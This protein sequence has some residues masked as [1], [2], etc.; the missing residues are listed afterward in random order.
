LVSVESD[1]DED[2]HIQQNMSQ[3]S[4]KTAEAKIALK[5]KSAVE[6][7]TEDDTKTA[8]A[9]LL[10]EI[11]NSPLIPGPFLEQRKRQEKSVR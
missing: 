2:E 10:Y 4:V 7:Q 9:L 6:V 1:K 8:K 5:P 11:N 3:M